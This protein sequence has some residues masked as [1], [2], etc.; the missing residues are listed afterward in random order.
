M[1][2]AFHHRPG[3]YSD[4]WIDYCQKHNIQY[5]IVD[6][7]AND[8]LE[9][10]A[11]CDAFMWHF[12]H[13]IYKDCLFA[14]QL[15]YV[16][17]KHMGKYTYP[18]YDT[19][20]HF[21]DKI[22][23]KYL[24]EAIDAPL[25]PTYIFYTRQDAIKWIQHTFFPKVFKL[26]CGASG[27]TVQLLQNHKQAKH[28]INRAFSSGI[29]TFRYIE[30]IK[31][32]YE[33]HKKGLASIRA[34][35]GLIKMWLLRISPNEYYRFHSKEIGYVYFQDYM[36]DNDYD[37]RVFVVG[38]RAVAKKRMNRK[39]DFRA[40]GSGN[41]VFDKEQINIE[42]IKTAFNINKRLKMQS[43][44]FD[45]LKDQNNKI[46]LS[47]ISYCC[48]IDSNKGY[49]GYWTQD[50]QWHDCSNINICYW[51]IENIITAI[52]KP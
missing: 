30:L 48:G 26:S 8:I 35:L 19:C 40:S 14:K 13:L 23:Q 25:V 20:W 45:F 18:N 34:F 5:K 46:V 17:E 37:I 41:L 51:I 9:Q 2:I 15:I 28:I 1:K 27:S 29:K 36:P 43:V 32:Q 11:D 47:E 10:V 21:D 44:A 7:Y 50:L 39:N 33:K 31:D 38:N 4:L 22:G 16:I 42:Y 52:E 49:N 6:A 12:H 3:S 24:L